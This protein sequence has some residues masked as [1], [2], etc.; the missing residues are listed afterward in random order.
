[1]KYG[2][3]KITLTDIKDGIPGED[4]NEGTAGSVPDNTMS[5]IGHIAWRAEA[6]FY[7]IKIEGVL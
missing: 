4:G 6:Q 5:V 2:T 3:G 7:K 1:M